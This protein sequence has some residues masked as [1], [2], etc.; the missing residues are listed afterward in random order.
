MTA[1]DADGLTTVEGERPLLSPRDRRLLR[2]Q[3]WQVPA[4]IV[5]GVSFMAAGGSYGIWAARRLRTTSSADEATAFDRPI[6]GL[7]GVLASEDEARLRT[8]TPNTDLERSLLLELRRKND[9]LAR[10]ML[11]LLR[12]LIGTLV[13]G[14]GG[15]L[16]AS[17]F[18]KLPL[19]R[20]VRTLRA[21]GGDSR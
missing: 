20:I 9:L 11:A 12:L 10:L 3:R 7:V 16:L 5:L 6:A 8:L 14:A 2:A 21:D 19:L 17:A 15:M 18:S 1:R 13:L 4:A